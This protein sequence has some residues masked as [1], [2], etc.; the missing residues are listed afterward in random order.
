LVS[1]ETT[2]AAGALIMRRSRFGAID[3]QTALAYLLADDSETRAFFDHL[4]LSDDGKWRRS[5]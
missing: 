3:L 2:G 1:T 5:P 4:I